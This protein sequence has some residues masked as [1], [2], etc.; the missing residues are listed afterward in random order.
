[1]PRDDANRQEAI[2]SSFTRRYEQIE[3]IET[4]KL[5]YKIVGQAFMRHKFADSYGLTQ[6]YVP[7]CIGE[8]FAYSPIGDGTLF[9]GL[10]ANALKFGGM[11]RL[12]HKRRALL[13]QMSKGM[14]FSGQVS[15]W[16]GLAGLD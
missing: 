3:E 4:A 8:L 2:S 16:G 11:R 5:V 13:R 15:F 7:T 10:A 12:L 9:G 14:F 6:Y 1:V